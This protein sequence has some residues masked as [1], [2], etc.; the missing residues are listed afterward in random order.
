M[1][2]ELAESF[3]L[4]NALRYGMLPII[5]ASSEPERQVRD[6]DGLYL[7]EEVQAEGFV[8]N[9]GNFTLV[10]VSL[11]RFNGQTGMGLKGTDQNEAAPANPRHS[12]N[13][14]QAQ[15]IPYGLWSPA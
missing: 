3:R 10:L 12:R 14:E 2:A 4:E 15:S 11:S 9:F 6:C 7:R 1:A 13:A 5:H 8:R